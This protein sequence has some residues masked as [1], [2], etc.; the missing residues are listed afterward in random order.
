[1]QSVNCQPSTPASPPARWP[2]HVRHTSR[3]ET[4]VRKTAPRRQAIRGENGSFVVYSHSSP[5]SAHR[6]L[7]SNADP[8]T[9][10]HPKGNL[11]TAIH[12]SIPNATLPGKARPE[13][14]LATSHPVCTRPH[15]PFICPCL[16]PSVLSCLPKYLPS[17]LGPI[18][19]L[20]F[21]GLSTQA[22]SRSPDL[23]ATTLANFSKCSNPQ[24]VARSHAGPRMHVQCSSDSES[25]KS[26]PERLAENQ[27]KDPLVTHECRRS[28]VVLSPES[29]VCPCWARCGM[30]ILSIPAHHCVNSGPDQTI[31][32]ASLTTRESYVRP[33]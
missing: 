11:V 33:S 18:S 8:S 21:R 27:C 31:K 6:A 10:K 26:I 20:S 24:N 32:L 2:V 5:A 13:S 12:T 25:R 4:A 3:D 1:M 7:L 16:A 9:V 23:A 14:Q 22:C 19:M 29:L 17:P 28:S 30:K 15:H